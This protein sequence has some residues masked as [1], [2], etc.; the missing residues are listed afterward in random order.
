MTSLD[1][2]YDRKWSGLRNPRR[3]GGGLVL[4]GA[5]VLG[6]VAAM[7]LVGFQAD[8]TTAKQYAGVAAGLGVPAMLLGVAVVLPAS[9]RARAGVVLGSLVSGAGVALF[10]QVYPARWTRTA[11]P[12][13]FE[14]MMLY[15]LGCAIALWFVFSTIATFRLRNNPQGTVRLEVVRQG[16]TQ[17]V[18]V[19]R[20]RYRQMVSDGGDAR[21]VIRE[22]ED[23]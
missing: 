12:L 16:E 20:D 15:G 22:L 1:E 14:T 4:V 17:T 18:E 3:V 11:D 23:R 13:A 8:S 21:A 5:G 9:S 7:A 10:W 6:V 19:S 2:A